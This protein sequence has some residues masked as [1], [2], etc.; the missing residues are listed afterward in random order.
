MPLFLS[1]TLLT[2][3]V[4][5]N[6]SKCAHIITLQKKAEEQT[7]EEAEA[8]AEAEDEEDEEERRNREKEKEREREKK[9]IMSIEV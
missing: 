6:N 8:S 7:K 3:S 4:E 2:L 5:M 1:L 9:I